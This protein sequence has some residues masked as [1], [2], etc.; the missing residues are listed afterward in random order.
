MAESEERPG[1][2]C[3]AR[4]YGEPAPQT[5]DLPAATPVW[6]ATAWPLTGGVRVIVPPGVEVVARGTGVR[7]AFEPPGTPPPPDPG[8]PG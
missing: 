5:R 7:G 1:A 2:A 4:T 8:A 6:F 3:R